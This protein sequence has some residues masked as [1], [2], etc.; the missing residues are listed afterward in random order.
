M[1]N[2][3]A[4]RYPMGRGATPLYSLL[5]GEHL[6]Y[7]RARRWI[8]IPLYRNSVRKTESWRELKDRFRARGEITLWDFDGYNRGNKTL[9]EVLNDPTRKMGHAF[10]LAMMLAYGDDFDWTELP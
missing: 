4:V 5:G 2:P 10:V 9:R 1:S 7:V 6:D 3:R 8:Y